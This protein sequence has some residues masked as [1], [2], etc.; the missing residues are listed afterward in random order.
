MFGANVFG[1]RELRRRLP[2]EA[3]DRFKKIGAEGKSIDPQ[4]AGLIADAMKDW[5]LEQGASHYCHW[6][7]P[8]TGATA[9]KHDSF[10]MPEKDG[11]AIAVFSGKQLIKGEPDASSF[12]SGGLRSTF[13]ARGYTV[14][15]SSSPAFL[16]ED[17]EGE[18]TLY[19]PTAFCSWS[20]QP[21]DQ[22]TGLLRSMSVIQTQALRVLRALGNRT[23]TRVFPTVGPE[24]EYFL[25]DRA[26]WDRRLDLVLTGRTL[27]G[28][29]PPKGQEMEDHYFGSITDRV[30]AFMTD[31]DQEL[32]KL[33]VSAKT[34]HNEVSPGQYESAAVF[35]VVNVACDHNQ[36]VMEMMR[37]VALRH[38]F[39]CLLHEKPFAGV[40]GSGKH[41]NWSLATDDGLNLLEPGETPHDNEQFLVFLAAVIQ[42]VDSHA[43]LLRASVAN[44]GNDH[45]LGANEAPPAI[46]SMFLGPEL[47]E[48]L[49]KLSRGEAASSHGVNFLAMGV[50]HLPPLPKENSDRNRTSSFAFTG[51]KF[52]FRMMPSSMSTAGANLV[53][54]TIVAEALD[55]IATRLEAASDVN[56]EAAAI[57]REIVARHGRIVFNGNNYEAAWVEEA[58]RRG[59]PNIRNTVDALHAW[60]SPKTVELFEKYGVYTRGDLEARHEIFLETYG[61]LINIEARTAIHMV[62]RQ[63]LPAGIE[64]ATRLADS[65]AKVRSA[66]PQASTGAQEGALIQVSALLDSSRKKLGGLEELAVE[67]RKIEDVAER[68][69]FF[70]DR[71]LPAMGE[72]RA[73]IDALEPL[74]DDDLWPT[75]T[76]VDLLYRQ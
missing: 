38:D 59:L 8:L 58:V 45:R 32:W 50:D 12:P 6:F 69:R 29:P 36:L 70:R 75:P 57:V 17:G 63:Y 76:Y 74:V 37:K 1:D 27:F 49:F 11:S 34:R 2:R 68:A 16:K 31:L 52:E 26:L 22:K 46:V 19:I 48:I 25:V 71:V 65:I 51:N 44:A 41:N 4:L 64:F 35:G 18:V 60:A 7:Q 9:E 42:A 15:D 61:K 20:G 62:S 67:G 56:V 33:G 53:L 14:W 73:D 54:N 43:E 66:T 55:S 5:A 28:A 23:S 24:Q 47:T 72:L 39:V 30:I 10:L 21:L 40:N 13:E 3:F